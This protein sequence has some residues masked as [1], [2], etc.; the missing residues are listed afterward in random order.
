MKYSES[1]IDKKIKTPRVYF[2]ITD[3]EYSLRKSTRFT[4][5]TPSYEKV[6]YIPLAIPDTRNAQDY[7]DSMMYYAKQFMNEMFY[8]GATRIRNHL[9]I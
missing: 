5:D 6:F 8:A 3:F 7:W 2:I 4:K 1:E 9:L